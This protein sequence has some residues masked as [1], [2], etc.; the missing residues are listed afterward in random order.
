MTL[1]RCGQDNPD[2]AKFCLDCGRRLNAASAVDRG[3]LRTVTAVFS[4]V[5]GSTELARGFETGVWRS[6]MARYFEMARGVLEHHGGTVQKFA[7]DAVMA[8]FGAEELHEDDALRATNAA[9][10]LHERLPELNDELERR[11]RA[12]FDLHT[13]V[14]TGEVSTDSPV[15]GHMLVLGDAINMA[16]RLQKAAGRGEILIGHST[17][18]LVRDSVT[19]D[20]VRALALQGIGD[21]V[22]AWRLLGIYKGPRPTARS[23]APLVDRELELALL[24]LE[25]ERVVAESRCHLVTVRGDG[26]VGK[27]RL[28]DEFSR[29][30]RQRATVLRGSC[31]PYGD[32]ITDHPMAQILQQAAGIQRDDAPERVREKVA[33]LA[34]GDES[35]TAQA[36]RLLG[37]SDVAGEPDD[38]YR[39]LRRILELMAERRPLVVLMDDLH[40][41]RPTLLEFIGYV[42]ESFRGARILLVC[43]ARSEFFE[44]H[45]DWRGNIANSASIQLSPLDEAQTGQLIGLLLKEGEPLPEV[46]EHIKRAAMGVPLYVEEL[47]RWLTDE[48]TLYLENG[49]WVLAADSA[50]VRTPPTIQAVL[51][52]RLDRLEP[53]ER[54]VIERAAVIGMQFKL[55]EVVAMM[56]EQPQQAASVGT[57][58]MGLVRKELLQ[59]DPAGAAGGGSGEDSFRFR[60]ILIQDTAYGRIGKQARADLHEQFASWLEGSADGS[61]Y[62]DQA[63]GFHLERAYR[64]RLELGGNGSLRELARRAGERLAAAGHRGVARGESPASTANLLRRAI[65][66]LPRDHP[67]RLQAFLDLADAL[68]ESKLQEAGEKYAEII[69]A[70]KAVGNEGAE[71]HAVLGRLEVT[72]SHDLQRDWNKD[73]EQIQKAIRV[74]EELGDELGGAKAW[75]LLA[76][77]HAGM[78]SSRAARAEAEHAIT[79]VRRT[80]DERLEAKIRRL[81]GVVLFWGPTQ[82]D[83]VVRENEEAVKWARQKGMVS[84]EA[85]ALSLLARAA[86]MRGDFPEARR[87]NRMAE[88]LIPDLGELLT[89]AADSISEGLVELLADNLEAAERALRRGYDALERR[90]ITGARATIAAMLARV[91]LRL[92][93]DDQA[94]ELLEVCE[95][96]S[97]EHQ[98]DNQIKWRE[99][100]ALVLANRGELEEAVRL[101]R[102]AVDMALRSEQ[103]NSQADAYFDLGVV[104]R[105][106]GRPDEAIR[107]A[108]RARE[109][110]EEK[111]NLVQSRRVQDWLKATGNP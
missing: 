29:G 65:E 1:C 104:L 48:Q 27:S 56:P 51:A 66:L 13:G 12:R 73:L 53:P 41:A 37:L 62:F 69:E 35:L 96:D 105:A 75:R 83:E 70:A 68:R 6:V 38:T 54:A 111:G 19:V 106:A 76:Y 3:A 28:V 14:N 86:A 71:M 91:L 103:V 15:D 46:E 50:E 67:E 23:D 78:G 45:A 44:E 88:R 25:F 98:L 30:I 8:V 64:Y 63:L 57:T 55:A 20:L 94:E 49:Q 74:F 81:Y 7:G 36:T 47:V 9:F 93:R 84:L 32:A 80:G 61:A 110:F 22:N 82:L 85:G 102:E 90:G 109:L 58:L 59:L 21:A 79:L 31:L 107:A 101:A 18:R 108:T 100:R 34:G 87:L 89:V 24:N 72:W 95:K 5:V 99:L 4:D 97:A 33:R 60:H 16:S 39:A 92:G 77:A 43:L 26:G 42:A 10:E 40:W 11:W 2:H 52:A 17:Y